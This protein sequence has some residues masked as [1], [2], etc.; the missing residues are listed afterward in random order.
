MRKLVY[1]TQC[2]RCDRK[3]MQA[4]SPEDLTS[5]EPEGEE[6]LSFYATLA[7]AHDEKA[8]EVRFQDL[9]TP[10]RRT[11]RALLEQVGKKIE[12]V[13]PDRKPAEKKAAP[14]KSR[15]AKEKTAASHAQPSEPNHTPPATQLA[16]AAVPSARA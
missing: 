15:E 6:S 7:A 2:S 3:E 4:A 9:C 10:C 13:S 12:G 1:E 16:K 14:K 11:I 8:L 5:P